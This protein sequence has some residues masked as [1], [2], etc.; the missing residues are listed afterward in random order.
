MKSY[1]LTY[2]SLRDKQTA[3]VTWRTEQFSTTW[4]QCSFRSELRHPLFCKTGSNLHI[5]KKCNTQSD[6]GL[7]SAHLS[8]GS[9]CVQCYM[10]MMPTTSSV[11]YWCDCVFTI[12][13]P[14]SEK[15]FWN[16]LKYIPS[17]A[18]DQSVTL[19]HNMS[20]VDVYAYL[21]LQAHLQRRAFGI[22]QVHV[23]TKSSSRSDCTFMAQYVS[24]FSLYLYGTIC[25]LLFNRS[26]GHQGPE[27]ELGDWSQ[28]L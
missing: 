27:F 1:L 8:E 23:Y 18:P 19:W 11:I 24:C 10:F 12:A 16:I 14:S 20:P 15:G 7:H 25:L 5:S 22:Y 17:P 26:R 2:Y 9:F 6:L 4:G 21:L 3:H 13:G 28:V